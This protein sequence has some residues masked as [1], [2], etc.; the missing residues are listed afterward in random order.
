MWSNCERYR[1]LRPLFDAVEDGLRRRRGVG[2]QRQLGAG[3]R[4]REGDPGLI[5][6]WTVAERRGAARKDKNRERAGRL[7]A[8]VSGVGSFDVER[9]QRPLANE[10]RLPSDRNGEIL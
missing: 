6:T 5:G 4:R 3:K 9:D 2:L 7:A 1:R 10:D 8:A